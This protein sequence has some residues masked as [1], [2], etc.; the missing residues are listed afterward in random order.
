MSFF[1]IRLGNRN[2]NEEKEIEEVVT[3]PVVAEPKK[4]EPVVITKKE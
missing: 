4:R 3:K 2:V 1:V